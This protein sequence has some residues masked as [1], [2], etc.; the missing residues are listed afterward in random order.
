MGEEVRRAVEEM[1]ADADV[2]VLVVTGEGKA[3]S[4]GGDLGMLARDAGVSDERTPAWAARRASSTSASWRFATSADPDHRRDQRPRHRRRALL[5]ARLRPAHRHR[6]RQDGHDLHQ[7][8]HPSRHGRDLLPAAPDRHR[9]GLRAA[10]HRPHHRRRR[11]RAAGHRSTAS[12]PARR[13]PAAVRAL[14]GEIAAA[15]ADRRAHGQ[16]RA[17]PRPRAR[18]STTP[19]TSSRC[20]RRR[21]SRPPTT[22]KEGIRADDGESASRRSSPGQ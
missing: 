1:R 18:R 21:P 12:S 7:A 11:G 6:R 16:A 9:A 13:F 15:G 17:L 10:V 5:R 14:A 19:S 20:S 8:R 2:R 22:R 4:G 3:F